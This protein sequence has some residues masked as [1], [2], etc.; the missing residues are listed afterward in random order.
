MRGAGVSLSFFNC[1]TSTNIDCILDLFKEEFQKACL[2]VFPARL[3]YD[4]TKENQDSNIFPPTSHFDSF[5]GFVIPLNFSFHWAVCF[6][7]PGVCFIFDSAPNVNSTFFLK[8]VL[9]KHFY[10]SNILFF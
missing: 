3:F 6:Y 9:K 1:L 8:R 10:I 2:K 4:I 5:K 7:F